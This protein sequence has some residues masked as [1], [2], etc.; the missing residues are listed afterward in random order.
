MQIPKLTVREKLGF[1]LLFFA[2]IVVGTFASVA[3]D[4]RLNQPHSLTGN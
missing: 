1:V 2:I 3:T 4:P